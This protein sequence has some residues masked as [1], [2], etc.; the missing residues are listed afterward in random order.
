MAKALKTAALVVGAVA[1]VATGVGAAASAGLIGVGIGSSATVLGVTA[2]TLSTIG[3]LAGIGA[4]VLSVG[5]S[6]LTKTPP[7]TISGNQTKF[8]AAIDQ[9]IPYAVGRTAISGFIVHRQTFD[10]SNSQPQNAF[11][12]FFGIWSWGRSKNDSNAVFQVEGNPV[13]FG[14]DVGNDVAQGGYNDGHNTGWMWLRWQDGTQTEAVK[15]TGFY[16]YPAGWSASSKMS[17]YS[18][19]AW[20]LKFDESG[21]AYPGAV[22]PQPRRIDEWNTV[23]DPR[24]DSTY[25]GGSGTCRALDESTYVWSRCPALHALTWALGRWDNGK[26]ILGMGMALA[27]I[28]VPAFVQAAN[29]HD[30]NGWEVGGVVYSTDGKWDV[31]KKMLA[32]GSAEPLQLG[33]MLSCTVDAPRTSLATITDDDIIG[34]CTVPG[35]ARMRDRIN[36][37]IPTCRLEDHDWQLVPCAKVQVDS[38]VA[39]DTRPRTKAMTWELVQSANQVAELATYA[40]CNSREIDGIVV[41]LKIRWIGYKGGDALTIQSPTLGMESQLVVVRK[42]QLEPTTGAVTLTMRSETAE[43]HPFSLGKTTT[44]PPQ[45]A[46]QTVDR[47]QLLIPGVSASWSATRDDNGKRPEDNATNTADPTSPWGDAGQKV[48]DAIAGIKAAEDGVASLVATYGTTV[49]ATTSATAADNARKAAEAARDTAVGASGDAATQAGHAQGYAQTATDQAGAA[50]YYANLSSQ[51]SAGALDQNPFFV[52]WDDATQP[53]AGWAWWDA[54]AGIRRDTGQQGRPYAAAFDPIANQNAGILQFVTTTFG[55]YV[56]EVTGR[57]TNWNGAGLLLNWLNPSGQYMGEARINCGGEKDNSGWLSNV[58]GGG[59]TYQRTWSKLFTTPIDGNVRSFVLYAMANWEGFE[60]LQPSGVTVHRDAKSISFDS[61]VF[62]KATQPEIDAGA[63]LSGLGAKADISYAQ[64]VATDA[65]GNALTAAQQDFNSKFSGTVSTPLL[66]AINGKASIADVNASLLDQVSTGAGP[67][68]AVVSRTSTL[69]AK[70]RAGSTWNMVKNSDFSNGLANWNING[71]NWATYVD[72]NV[73]PFV[74]HA[75]GN[76]NPLFQDIPI[77]GNTDYA[78]SFEGNSRQVG[79]PQN[80]YVRVQWWDLVNGGGFLGDGVGQVLYGTP[81]DAWS[82]RMEVYAGHSPANATHARILLYT[83]DYFDVSRIQFQ[84]GTRPTAYRRDNDQVDV[85]A[86]LTTAQGVLATLDGRT[87]AYFRVGAY[88]SAGEA[89]LDLVSDSL[90]GTL[91]RIRA[92]TIV[93]DGDVLGTGTVRAKAFVT[94]QGVDLAAIV[95]GT[96]SFDLVGNQGLSQTLNNGEQT[97]VVAISGAG[98][99]NGA[100]MVIVD[101]A[102]QYSGPTGSTGSPDFVTFSSYLQA[103]FVWSNNGGA[104]WNAFGSTDYP[105][106][107]VVSTVSWGTGTFNVNSPK[108]YFGDNVIIGVILRNVSNENGHDSHGQNMP[109]NVFGMSYRARFIT[110][111]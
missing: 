29:V 102:W 12:T 94:D 65:A 80:S 75:P 85:N 95:N 55:A 96:F 97:G 101:G 5:S 44:P 2:G 3:T 84:P 30:V 51:T 32:A 31:I 13:T 77:Y 28:D 17:G 106:T 79:N 24:Q 4:A 76:G 41:P 68:G 45:P 87:T 42:R 39:A 92:G 54:S 62:R 49:A 64:Q 71:G 14:G 11:Q 74:A 33:G 99:F 67:L 78:L 19:F 47:T 104:S 81:Q 18:D 110:L 1:L 50:A 111:K 73:G 35:G 46:L 86:R 10:W 63:A 83:G 23:Y 48:A 25:P 38:Y 52:K 105:G 40:I 6:L 90:A 107:G 15:A 9:G 56:I 60:G 20:T 27:A 93:L 88:S 89:L 66:T 61:V 72:P 37:V 91:F 59:G 108:Y 53:P 109:I 103:T 58:D 8:T 22:V 26:R 82:G 7:T 70:F 98:N 16:P 69:E 36:G 57:A 43:K 21:K 100:Q 34:A